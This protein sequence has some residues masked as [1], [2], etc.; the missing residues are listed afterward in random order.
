MNNEKLNKKA[1]MMTVV[2]IV[3]NIA[4]FFITEI[5]G[6]TEDT[7]FMLR[8]GAM[9]PYNVTELGE[10]WRI[11]TANYLHF[12]F[13]HLINNMVVLGASGM[14][15][16]QA[17]GKVKFSILYIASGIGGSILSL[18]MMLKTNDIAVAAGA[19]GAVFGIFGGL[20]WVVIANRGRYKDL[21][22]RGVI[23]MIALALYYGISS[24][25]VDNWGHVG[26]LLTGIVIAVLLY[27]KVPQNDIP[28]NVDFTDENQYT[29]DI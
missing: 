17:M 13:E 29:N 5:L 24:T 10:W 3:I 8:A 15:L 22:G 16:E 21:N 27:R 26:G 28:S 23:F 2:F 11:I 9:F 7:E 12:G 6:D 20:L 19:S 14:V 1:P 18:I 25:G 4:V